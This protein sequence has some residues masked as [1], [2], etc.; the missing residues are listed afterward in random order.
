M[1][2]MQLSDLFQ[3]DEIPVGSPLRQSTYIIRRQ[4]CRSFV[5]YLV[6][7]RTHTGLGRLVVC[8]QYKTESLSRVFDDTKS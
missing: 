6:K 3:S 4:G 8:D 2:E 5:L 7:A 1:L